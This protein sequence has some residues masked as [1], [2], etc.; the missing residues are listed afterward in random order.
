MLW[1]FG[2]FSVSPPPLSWSSQRVSP[3]TNPESK[4]GVQGQEGVGKGCW[5]GGQPVNIRSWVGYCPGNGD[6][7]TPGTLGTL[8]YWEVSQLGYRPQWLILQWLM[9]LWIPHSWALPLPHARA[10]HSKVQE[11][12]SFTPRKTERGRNSQASGEGSAGDPPGK[13]RA[14][15]Q[16]MGSILSRHR[17]YIPS[18]DYSTWN[19]TGA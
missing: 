13:L 17:C 16:G 3:K 9:V 14:L 5:K 18:T 1:Q 6:P 12:S 7:S 11:N 10:K 2:N 4:I 19:P 8:F 15:K